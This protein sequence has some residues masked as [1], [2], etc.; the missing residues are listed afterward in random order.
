M[1]G[2]THLARAGHPYP[3]LQRAN[4]RV[5]QLKPE[6]FAVGL[7]PRSEAAEAEFLFE[8]GDRLFLYSDGLVEATSAAGERFSSNRLVQIVS[9]QKGSPL[10]EVVA[11]LGSQVSSWRGEDDFDDDVSLVGLERE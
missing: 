2:I 11:Q 4:G 3:I 9:T 6:G 10:A 1:T 8:R 5:E 7:F